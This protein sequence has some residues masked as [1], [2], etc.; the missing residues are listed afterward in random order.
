[1]RNGDHMTRL[2]AYLPNNHTLWNCLNRANVPYTYIQDATG[3]EIM[4]MPQ[5]DAEYMIR[6]FYDRLER[7]PDERIISM[8]CAL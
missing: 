5:A 7:V 6:T 8:A 3:L 4:S 2:I 1:M